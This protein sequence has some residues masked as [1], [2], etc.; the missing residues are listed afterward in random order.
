VPV[1][2]L[3]RL[4]AAQ[5]RQF[6]DALAHTLQAEPFAGGLLWRCVIV[7]ESEQALRLI[8][9]FHHGVFDGFSAGILRAEAPRLAR[10]ERLPQARPYRRFLESLTAVHD[11]G[12][13]LGAFDYDAWLAANRAVTTAVRSQSAALHG[14]RLTVP[15]H[16]AHPLELAF[17]TVHAQ[18]SDLTGGTRIAVG[19]VTDCRRWQDEGYTDSVGEF[20]DVVPVLLSGDG[21]QPA[22]AERLTRAREQGLHYV[23]ALTNDPAAPPG[24]RTAY[25][26]ERGTLA[27]ALL[28]FQGRIDTA[29]M[30]EGGPDDGPA[31]AP[32]HLNVW[33]DDASLHLEWITDQ[34]RDPAGDP[35]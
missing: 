19:L 9:A 8:W 23:H 4:D 18:L 1:R 35:A 11:W 20:L 3:R 13:E 28:N 17:E 26:N 27:L 25:R 15:L 29:D 24:L 16:D 34:T 12:T 7:R 10:G 6:N 30:P 22:A 2:D 33:H 21:D 14:K 31:L 32:L 5:V